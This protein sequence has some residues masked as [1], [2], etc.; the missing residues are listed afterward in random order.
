MVV[1]DSSDPPQKH[2]PR[3]RVFVYRGTEAGDRPSFLG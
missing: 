1:L 2:D 3:G